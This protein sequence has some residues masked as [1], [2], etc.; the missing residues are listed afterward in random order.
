MRERATPICGYPKYI[1]LVLK[2][3][4]TSIWGAKWPESSTLWVRK[5]FLRL[6][7][8]PFP[9]KSQKT[10]S[11]VTAK[12]EFRYLCFWNS[13]KLNMGFKIT[14]IIDFMGT[15]SNSEALRPS[16]LA[17]LRRSLPRVWHTLFA[18][19]EIGIYLQLFLKVKDYTYSIWGSKWPVKL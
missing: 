4:D 9:R 1:S 2:V 12:A 10:A 13:K 17:L 3:V 5:V 6:Y 19:C 8:L 18:T 14:T 16:V 7:D 15:E 11:R